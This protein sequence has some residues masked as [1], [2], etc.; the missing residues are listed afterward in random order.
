MQF[1][2]LT[3]LYVV[4]SVIVSYLP[5]FSSVSSASSLM[6]IGMRGWRVWGG[7]EGEPGSRRMLDS[8]ESD[9]WSSD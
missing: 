7:G 3:V 4:C 5:L 6:L 2:R 9:I 1:Y 8:V